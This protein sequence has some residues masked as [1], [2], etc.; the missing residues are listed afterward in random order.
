MQKEYLI[1][2]DELKKLIQEDSV[3]VIDTR[4]PEAFNEAHIS[5]AV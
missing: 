5:G 3:F 1:E 4:S 2:D